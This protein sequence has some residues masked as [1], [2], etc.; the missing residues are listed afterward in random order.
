MKVESQ[1]KTSR[2][3][4]GHRPCFEDSYMSPRD[5][6]VIFMACQ[7]WVAEHG[8]EPRRRAANGFEKCLASYVYCSEN[9]VPMTAKQVGMLLCNI[10]FQWMKS[11]GDREPRLSSRNLTE[12]VIAEFA[13]DVREAK[14]QGRIAA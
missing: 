12:Q 10:L 5:S 13:R 11:H 9:D 8:G 14:A 7:K 1:G 6:E 3:P 2:N 4:R